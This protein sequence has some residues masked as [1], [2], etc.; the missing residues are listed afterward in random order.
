MTRHRG[1]LR[2]RRK[3]PGRDLGETAAGTSPKQKLKSG[4]ARNLNTISTAIA[5]GDQDRPLVDRFGNRHRPSVLTSWSPAM[6]Q[7]MQLRSIPDRSR[8]P[9]KLNR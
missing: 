9:V 4:L 1:A 8:P 2:Y 5:E 3:S 6:V 7:V